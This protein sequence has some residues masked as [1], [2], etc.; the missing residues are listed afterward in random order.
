MKKVI[1]K[2]YGGKVILG[3]RIDESVSVYTEDDK[4][5]AVTEE[6]LPFDASHDACGKYISPGFIDIHVHGGGGADFMDCTPEAFLTAA[7]LHAKYGT[8]CML[9][10]ASAGCVEEYMG[11]LDALE[12]AEKRNTKGAYMAGIHFEGPYFDTVQAGGQNPEYIRPP[13]KEEYEKLLNYS[14]RILRWSSAPE[15]EG[16][17]EFAKALLAHGVLPSIAHSNAEYEDVVNA[18]K[19][20]YTLITHLYSCMSTIHRI[21]AYRHVGIVEAAY[22]IDDMD[23]EIIADGSHLPAEL[24]KYVCKFKDHDRIAL[25]TDSL[26]GAGLPDGTLMLA[27]SLKNGFEVIIEDGVAKLMSREAFA[28][29]VCTTNKLVRNMINMADLSVPEAVKMATRNPARMAKLTDRGDL[30]DGKKAD[31]LIFDDDINVELTMVN[32]NI[33]FEK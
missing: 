27:G 8:T 10:T 16:T 19:W 26:R 31:I 25:I 3:D 6:N 1:H 14:N 17:E 33:V 29:S 7:E 9:P 2:F 4:I 20:G 22:L 15:L 21:N 18:H 24:L 5:I 13:Q 32:G 11:M 23:V 12:E 28:G 30:K